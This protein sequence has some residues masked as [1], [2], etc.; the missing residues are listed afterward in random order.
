MT[1]AVIGGEE[2][3]L[4]GSPIWVREAVDPKLNAN[5]HSNNKVILNGK[6]IAIEGFV[7]YVDIVKIDG[8]NITIIP[9]NN[10]TNKPSHYK[11]SG[12][13]LPAI[14]VEDY[15]YLAD[16][17]YD[18]DK[19]LS[20]NINLGSQSDPLVIYV[21]GN[22]YLD[23]VTFN[24]Y[25]IV[26]AEKEIEIV[27]NVR[28]S[29]PH[30]DHSK[31]FIVGG[32]KFKL[33]NSSTTLHASVYTKYEVNINAEDALIEGSLATRE[34]NTLNGKRIDMRFKPVYSGLAEMIFGSK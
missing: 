9:N 21:A 12:V 24:G 23:R 34:K 6:K 11:V 30:P 29:S 14:N 13:N 16:I 27:S 7:T 4:N 25:G 17:I 32:D 8:D 20:G 28:S 5:V 2:V 33:N 18:G 31:V 10:P 1:Y 26:I 19:Q 15:K 3:T 22:L